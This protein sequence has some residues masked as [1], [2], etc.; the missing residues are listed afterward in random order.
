MEL[1]VADIVIRHKNPG[2][3]QE[4]V[5]PIDII[6]NTSDDELISNITTNS[7][8]DKDW[9]RV[10]DEHE[11][12]AILCGSGPSIADFIEDIR[13]KQK[14]GG[15]VFAMNGCAK[16]LFEHGI[17]PDYQVICDARKENVSLIGP[18]KE[19][20]FASQCHPD[21]FS[22]V[23]DAQLW[24]LQ[25]GDIEKYFPPYQRSYALIGGAA[26]V[27]NTATCLVYAMGYRAMDI[28][29]YDSCHKGTESHAFDQPLNHGEPC[30]YTEFNG[31]K[32]LASFTMKHQ[33]EK[34]QETARAL[35]QMG[36]SINVFGDGLLPDIWRTPKQIMTEQDK[37]EKMWEYKSYRSM[38]PG[39]DCVSE[40]I[41]RFKPQG[42]V[43]DFGC[44]TGRAG[45]KLSE[46]GCDVTLI[47]FTGNSRD[48]EAQLLPFLKHDLTMPI[49]LPN[50]AEYGY[51]T[52]VMEHI[53]PENV[54]KVVQNIMS[55]CKRCFFQISTVPDR[56]G[57]LIG[58]DLHLT[59]KP[60]EWWADLI[61][62]LGYAVLWSRKEENAALFFVTQPLEEENA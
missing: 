28:Y 23:P 17:L 60:I 33:A 40:F 3:S 51:C 15:R 46:F 20:L 29:G 62:S 39:E 50:V 48:V 38:S 36:A 8:L 14:D 57:A 30:L 26:S 55:A 31:K 42:T 21:L 44:G 1:P 10:E 6:C 43:I 12:L 56:M 37:Y 2:T 7:Q 18:A 19:H 45:L 24:H 32:Y 35:Q 54:A 5:I 41:E 61:G 16:F 27:G 13:Q 11:G 59:V 4:L 53:E 47:D 25:I 34:F 49:P 58:Q 9:M 22:A 52:D